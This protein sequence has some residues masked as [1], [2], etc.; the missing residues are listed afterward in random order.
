MDD[1]TPDLRLMTADIVAA[2]AGSRNHVSTADLPN[3]ISS[4]HAALSGLGAPSVQ[5][6]V[7]A[8]PAVSI[9]KAVQPDAITCLACGKR[10]K[11]LRRHIE[12][13]HGQTPAEFRAHWALPATFPM[14]APN[15]ASARS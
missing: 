15:Y 2:Y 8:E 12:N 3:L 7:K 4:V 14:V 13:A 1:D 6:P 11:S 9:R 10:F 5:E